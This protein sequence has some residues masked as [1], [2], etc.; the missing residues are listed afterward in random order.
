VE[1]TEQAILAGESAVVIVWLW[2]G[3]RS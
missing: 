3:S 2:H 1:M